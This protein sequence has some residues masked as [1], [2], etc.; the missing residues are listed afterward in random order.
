MFHHPKPVTSPFSSNI[1]LH[2]ISDSGNWEVICVWSTFLLFYRLI[3]FL[4]FTVAFKL[5]S[6]C[7]KAA[8]H[9]KISLQ[10]RKF[11]CSLEETISWTLLPRIKYVRFW[12]MPYISVGNRIMDWSDVYAKKRSLSTQMIFIY[13]RVNSCRQVMLYI[14]FLKLLAKKSLSKHCRLGMKIEGCKE[15]EQSQISSKPFKTSFYLAF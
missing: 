5:K 10:W 3:F 4:Y 6:V 11:C 15:V 8:N 13:Y 7:L 1:Y 14:S 12:Y 9:F 2:C